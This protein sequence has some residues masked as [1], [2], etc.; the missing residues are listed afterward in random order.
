MKKFESNE[1]V[2]KLVF[3]IEPLI[4]EHI[5]TVKLILMN[6]TSLVHRKG[7]GEVPA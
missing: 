4:F 7:T 2:P 1:E 3:L 6:L 5:E